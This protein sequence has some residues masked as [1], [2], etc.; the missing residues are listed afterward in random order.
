[1]CSKD[2]FSNSFPFSFLKFSQQLDQIN[3]KVWQK[4]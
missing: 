1:V 3:Y 2:R 4:Q